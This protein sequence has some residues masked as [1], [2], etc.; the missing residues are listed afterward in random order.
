MK[1][2]NSGK[3]GLSVQM[4]SL[5]VCCIMIMGIAAGCRVDKGLADCFDE[6]TLKKTGEQAV[7]YVNEKEYEK[8]REMFSEQY[9]D[10]V[11]EELFKDIISYS[12][13]MGEFEGFEKG[14]VIGQTIEET[15]E[16]FAGVIVVARYAEGEIQY[17]LGFTE[18]MKLIQFYI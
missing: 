2:N 10:S 4:I 18:D 15:G 3:A 7:T 13:K 9:K 12:D 11:T 8:F 17:R 5:A 6:D 14:A 16:N 1:I